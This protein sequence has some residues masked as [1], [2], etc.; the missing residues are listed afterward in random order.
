MLDHRLVGH[1]KGCLGGITP[2]C[3]I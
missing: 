3:G 1:T 2:V